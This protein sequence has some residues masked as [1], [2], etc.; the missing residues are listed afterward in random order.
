MNGPAALAAVAASTTRTV[1]ST[2]PGRRASTGRILLAA[3]ESTLD[4]L[5][6]LI[7]TLADSA[8][9]QI[10]IE[11]ASADDT[12][13][14]ATPELVT[15]TWLARESRSGNPGTSRRCAHGQALERAVLAWLSEMSTG[16]AER[17]D[18]EITAWIDGAG[19]RIWELR[20]ELIGRL[21]STSDAETLAL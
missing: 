15:V 11:V 9:G 21:G 8:R 14:I 12:A 6:N 7:D 4:A 3:D 13:P 16:D 1:R 20:Q 19:T 17:D 5:Q 18:G 10:F 2:R